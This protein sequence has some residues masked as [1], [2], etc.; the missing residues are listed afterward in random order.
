MSDEQNRTVSCRRNHGTNVERAAGELAFRPSVYGVIVKDGAV[1][2]LPQWDGYDFPGG[3]IDKGERIAEAL[4]R[5]VKEETGM[6]VEPG[7]LLQ[8]A[9]DFF[10]PSDESRSPMHSILM[11]YECAI[12]GGELSTAGFTK[13]EKTIAKLAEWVPLEKALTLKF[14]NP[15]DS[16]AVIRK[17]AG[18]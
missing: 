4:V 15:V 3:G 7:T 1:L 5:E 8:V 14:Y 17:A 16:P 18:L 12:T 9:D 13:F 11:Y 6:S 2:L 10:M